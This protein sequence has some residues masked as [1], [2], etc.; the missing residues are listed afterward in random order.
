MINKKNITS[1]IIITLCLVILSIIILNRYYS[2]KDEAVPVTANE[3]KKVTDSSNKSFEEVSEE[4]KNKTII[5]NGYELIIPSDYEN[6]IEDGLIISI[7]KINQVQLI[8]TI[9]PS[10]SFSMIEEDKDLYKEY[11]TESNFQVTNYEI[12]EINNNKWLIYYGTMNNTKT[13]YAI[14]AIYNS[15]FQSIIYNL[16][17]KTDNEVLEI[18]NNIVITAKETDKSNTENTDLGDSVT[19]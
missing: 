16:G 7:D 4:T 1:I 11:L 17:T 2:N 6:V 12:T 15:T 9:N 18:L 10:I 14:T 5:L 13:I 3:T 8:Y 19:A